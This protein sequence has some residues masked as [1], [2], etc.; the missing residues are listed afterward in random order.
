MLY[1]RMLFNSL[2]LIKHKY[3]QLQF[4]KKVWFFIIIIEFLNKRIFPMFLCKL[5]QFNKK[6]KFFRFLKI[7]YI[8]ILK[9]L[10]SYIL[11]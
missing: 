10:F 2:N 9:Y 1:T 6:I 4:G 3:I 8:F 5:I 7:R 11:I